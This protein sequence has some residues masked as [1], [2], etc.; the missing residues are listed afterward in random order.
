MPAQFGQY[1]VYVDF[2]N[3]GDFTDPREDITSRVL[4]GRAPVTIHY[5][6]DQARALSPTKV[7]EAAYEVNNRSRDYSP[8]NSSSPLTGQVLPGRRT[9][10]TGQVS[11]ATY[12]LYRGVWDDLDYRLGLDQRTV[13]ISSVDGLGQLRGVNVSTPLYRGLR[14]GEAIGLVLDAAGWSAT[15]RDLDTGASVLPFWWLDGVDA[16][17][18]LM[19]LADSEG[20]PA[21]ITVDTAGRV[22]F[23]D[24]HH[25]YTRAASLTSQST[26]RSYGSIEPT[27]SAPAG[28][29]YGFKDVVNVVE[30]QVP[31]RYLGEPAAVW[32]ADGLVSVASGETVNLIVRGSSAFANPVAPVAGVD[33]TLASGTVTIVMQQLSAESV[34]LAITAVSGPATIEGLQLR[35]QPV[36]TANTMT[37]TAEDATS[38]STYG[39]W[40]LPADR[41]PKWASL[42][43]A[44]SISSIILGQRAD[45]L[46]T[47]TVTMTGGNNTRLT[48]QLNRNLSDR[49]RIDDQHTGLNADC[50]V[51]QITHTITQG[52]REHRTTFGLEKAATQITGAFILGSATSGVLG[53]NRLGRRGF[54]DPNSIFILGSPTNGVLGSDVLAP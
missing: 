3:D 33:Y 40:S 11:G 8:D 49:V 47:M 14:T 18:A 4:D 54:A 46:P 51:E 25:R 26:W 22:V 50:F 16:F 28:Y 12:T 53:T 48:Q 6:R 17:A 7:G 15:L 19:D 39:R 37:V 32:S 9:M 34:L 5:G 45:R 10:I 2:N 43:D 36:V 35:A 31:Q 1:K 24:R 38:I 42:A 21:L 13:G 41:S 20:P 52:G 30:F 44:K 23:R 29:N 27:Y